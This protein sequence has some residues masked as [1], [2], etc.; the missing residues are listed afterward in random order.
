VRSGLEQDL[1]QVTFEDK[2][3]GLGFV[4]FTIIPN[5]YGDFFC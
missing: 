2:K 4:S 5:K 3:N 1:K